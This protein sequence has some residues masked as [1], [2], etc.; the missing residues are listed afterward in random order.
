M[1]IKQAKNSL[2]AVVLLHGG[3][4]SSWSVRPLAAL[5]EHDHQVI[6]PIID[7]HGENYA[8]TFTSIEDSARKLI[9]Y[10][11]EQH[12]GHIFALCGLSLGAQIA[13]EVLSQRK[14]IAE[15]AIIESALVLPLKG[16]AAL[17]APTYHLCYGLIKHRWFSMMQ[18]KSLSLPESMFEDYFRDRPRCPSN[19]LS[20]SPRAMRVIR[21]RRACRKPRQG[22]WSS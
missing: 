17:A 3:G 1:L 5:L 12:G 14:S 21:S 18:A 4:L 10:I 6:V 16:V 22:G 20:I 15:Y 11:D 8:E 7:G 2:P 9:A 19:L 13:V